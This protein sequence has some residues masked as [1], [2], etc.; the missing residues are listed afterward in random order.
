LLGS[1]GR[2]RLGA[3]NGGRAHVDADNRPR[4][5]LQSE[6]TVGGEKNFDTADF[7][8]GC[9]KLGCTPHFSRNASD[10]R[11]ALDAHEDV[12]SGS[13]QYFSHT[14]LG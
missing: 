6:W 12:R 14:W 8:A 1:A 3:G 9:R 2:A 5:L 11:S 4:D 13:V 7:V 10:R